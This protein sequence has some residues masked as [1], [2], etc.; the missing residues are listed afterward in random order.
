MVRSR[1][2]VV[3]LFVFLALQLVAA[4]SCLVFAAGAR[5]SNHD[6][7]DGTVLFGC[8]SAI[9][10]AVTALVIPFTI[11]NR[12][13]RE[14]APES[15]DLQ[16]SSPLPPRAFVDGKALGGAVLS[17][18][19]SAA[20]LPFM[21]VASLLGGVSLGM[22]ALAIGSAVLFATILS[23]AAVFCGATGWSPLMKRVVFFVVAYNGFSLVAGLFSA[24]LSVFVAG[25][26]SS[27]PWNPFVIIV[28]AIVVQLCFTLYLRACATCLLTPKNLNRARPVREAEILLW[29]FSLV[30]AV[31]DACRGE[32]TVL[33]VWECFW[34]V[35]LCVRLLISVSAPRAYSR[36]VQL[37][38]AVSPLRRTLQYPFFSGGENG[39]AFH[40]LMGL[41]TFAALT[42][43]RAIFP[44]SAVGVSS[45]T[46]G[47]VDKVRSVLLIVWAYLGFFAL[48]CR[49]IWNKF[50]VGRIRP[51]FVGL[52]A[53]FIFAV[54]CIV[55]GIV[56]AVQVGTSSP[57]ARDVARIM[58]FFGNFAGAI[59]GVS[60]NMP[61]IVWHHTLFS[62]SAFAVALL[63]WL[64]FL[65]RSLRDFKPRKV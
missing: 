27:L 43:L 32:F 40:L 47:W 53:F 31:L 54:A 56:T 58:G 38:I 64:P 1:S 48:L 26:A 20:T 2:L 36:R 35:F 10:G 6:A 3:S 45:L 55:P 59:Y 22:V 61:E 62:L 19:F 5:N 49:A 52:A 9:L 34:I 16:F 18:F 60:E 17:L 50:L 24:S 46:F 39:V 13:A 30:T 57:A 51:A 65:F 63:L 11:L 29:L 33:V 15:F 28:F 12:L 25:S 41:A 21:L 42:A 37:E 7:I 4:V 8:V 44:A 14:R 23:Y